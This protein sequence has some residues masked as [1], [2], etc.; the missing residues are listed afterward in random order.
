[1]R[2]DAEEANDGHND[3]E[4]NTSGGS[5]GAEERENQ[6]IDESAVGLREKVA[7][8]PEVNSNE[9]DLTTEAAHDNDNIIETALAKTK[10]PDNDIC[11]S[12][13]RFKMRIRT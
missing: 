5:G 6:G 8:L 7:M 10:N 11:E 1:M 4:S 12:L 3:E 13:S 2:A 9:E